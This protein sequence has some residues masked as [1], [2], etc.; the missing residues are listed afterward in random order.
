MENIVKLVFDHG[1][2]LFGVGFVAPLA[3]QILMKMN[4]PLIMGVDHIWLGLG[5]GIVWGL[6]AQVKGRWI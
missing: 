6:F 2:I 5:L 1:A 3:A 4:A